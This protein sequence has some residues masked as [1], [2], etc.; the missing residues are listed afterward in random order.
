MGGQADPASISGPFLSAGVGGDASRLAGDPYSGLELGQGRSIHRHRGLFVDERVEPGI[1]IKH[2]IVKI[3]TGGFQRENFSEGDL[4]IEQGDV[5]QGHDV[6]GYAAG[7]A[8]GEFVIEIGVVAHADEIVGGGVDESLRKKFLDGV[9]ALVVGL[10]HHQLQRGAEGLVDKGLAGVVGRA[11]VG[12]V[13]VHRHDRIEINAVAIN[14]DPEHRVKVVHD[15]DRGGGKPDKPVM[16]RCEY[17]AIVAFEIKPGIPVADVGTHQRSDRRSQ[18]VGIVQHDAH[19]ARL[20]AEKIRLDVDET[21]AVLADAIV[22]S[23]RI[24]TEIPPR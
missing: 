21:R 2:Q 10:L 13:W 4:L 19:V 5:G 22:D 18:G 3:D 15:L 16:Q 7:A 20:S 6:G 8:T 9:R 11:G 17:G 24:D 1:G 14:L 23:I 12:G